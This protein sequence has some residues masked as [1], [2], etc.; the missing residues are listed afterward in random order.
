MCA[1][2]TLD[3]LHPKAL[4]FDYSYSEVVKHNHTYS[5]GLV[6]IQVLSCIKLSIPISHWHG[7]SG[8]LGHV[9]TLGAYSVTKNSAKNAAKHVIFTQKNSKIFSPLPR[10]EGTPFSIS[11]RSSA[12]NTT[13][14]WLCHWHQVSSVYSRLQAVH[15]FSMNICIV[16]GQES[17]LE[18]LFY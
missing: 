16:Y 5:N 2:Y 4:L 17:H 15:K 1:E 13:R 9:P 7:H 18:I 8:A 10:G 11:H 6:N 14:S 12:P 3:W